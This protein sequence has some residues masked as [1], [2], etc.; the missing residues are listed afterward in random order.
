MVPVDPVAACC[1]WSKLAVCWSP[2]CRMLAGFNIMAASRIWTFRVDFQPRRPEQRAK[3]PGG[4]LWHGPHGFYLS[5]PK[6]DT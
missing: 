3:S 2:P 4:T 1:S 6:A 5:N